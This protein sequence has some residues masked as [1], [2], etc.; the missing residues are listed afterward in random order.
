MPL[1]SRRPHVLRWR[2]LLLCAVDQCTGLTS[3]LGACFTDHRNVRLSEHAPQ[4][5][6]GLALGDEDLC[7]STACARSP[8]AA[9]MCVCKAR[10]DRFVRTHC[11]ETGQDSRERWLLEGIHRTT[12]VGTSC[13]HT[14]VGGFSGAR[15]PGI[16]FSPKLVMYAG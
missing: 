16:R 4:R 9:R 1:L 5:L 13:E 10:V 8:W 3:R 14:P 7:A 12:R 2:A 15:T 11:P 6:F